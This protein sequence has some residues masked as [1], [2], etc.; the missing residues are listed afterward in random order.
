MQTKE[1][2][3]NFLKRHKRE[4][5]KRFSVRRIGLFGSY[6]HD[7]A[8]RASDVD[9]LVE[10]DRP[11]FDNYMDLKFFLE[12]QLKISVDLVLADSIK[13]RLRPIIT[14]EVAYA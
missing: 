11:T 2:I 13:P 8:G 7:M 12:D 3:F 4:L 9:I 14:R 1:E 5:S 6:L 10:L